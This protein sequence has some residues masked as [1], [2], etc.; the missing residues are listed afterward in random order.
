MAHGVEFAPVGRPYQPFIAGAARASAIGSGHLLRQV[1]YGLTQRKY[2]SDRLSQDA[3][4][5]AQGA[6]AII[7]KYSWIAGY[8]IAGKLGI[9]YRGHTFPLTPTGAF[10]SFM[11]GRGIDRGP[12][13]NRAVWSVTRQV[14]WQLLRSDDNALRRQLGLRPLP[15]QGPAARQQ[16]EAM[17]VYYA[18]SPA[19]LPRPAGRSACL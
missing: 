9:P 4:R 3:W 10:P 2:F 7:Y 18:F 6:E 12:R 16:R 8:T 19:V 13:L 1:R 14:V 11:L 5:A 17:P 15:L